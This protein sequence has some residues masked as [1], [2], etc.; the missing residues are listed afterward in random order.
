MPFDLVQSSDLALSVPL[1][2]DQLNGGVT[3]N[4]L[5]AH[6]NDVLRRLVTVVP[7]LSILLGLLL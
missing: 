1:I 3:R 6:P 7:G 2:D 4:H 5:I